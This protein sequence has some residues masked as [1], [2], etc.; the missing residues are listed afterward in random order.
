M[1]ATTTD[2]AIGPLPPDF[3][4]WDALLDLIIQAFAYMDGVV[5]PPSSAHRLTPASLAEK[6]AAET[7][8]VATAGGVPVGCVFLA[9][10]GDHFYLGKLAV[11]PA[12]QRSGLGRRLVA[13]AEAEAR[14]RGLAAIELQARVELIGNQHAFARL[15]FVETGRTA[16][17]GFD[18]PTSI[19]MRKALA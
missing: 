2:I 10:R 16:H 8:L 3:R 5:D 1:D 12:L 19:T 17:E 13:A 4:D 15:G 6:A 11:S 18:R 9:N 7:V 14:R